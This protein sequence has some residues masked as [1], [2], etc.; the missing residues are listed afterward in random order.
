MAFQLTTEDVIHHVINTGVVV[1]IGALCPWG[2]LLCL[3]NWSMCGFGGMTNYMFLFLYKKGVVSK[4]TEKY[5]N[6]WQNILLRYPIM[7]LVFY[8]AMVHIYQGNINVL[9]NPVTVGFMVL[10]ASLHWLNSLYYA[11]K[12][13]GNYHCFVASSKQAK[14]AKT[15]KKLQ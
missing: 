3:A 15:S 6:R 7:T 14:P 2:R 11:D 9:D 4:A 12:V 13:V 1:V 5:W 8:L 10:A